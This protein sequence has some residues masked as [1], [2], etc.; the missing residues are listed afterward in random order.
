M[1]RFTFNFKPSAALGGLG[2]ALPQRDCES[3]LVPFVHFVSRICLSFL[4]SFTLRNLALP[5]SL[6]T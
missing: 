2:S 3:P 6:C 4:L 5:L 1:V